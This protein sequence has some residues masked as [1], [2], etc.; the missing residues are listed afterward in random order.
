MYLHVIC[1]LVKGPTLPRG[2]GRYLSNPDLHTY[3]LGCC[4]LQLAL[5]IA[6]QRAMEVDAAI[7][8]GEPP[9]AVQEVQAA[10]QRVT[11]GA[12]VSQQQPSG[13][14]VKLQ[15]NVYGDIESSSDPRDETAWS[16]GRATELAFAGA[17]QAADIAE[18]GATPM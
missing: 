4:L 13:K 16:V 9:C 5:Q 15:G 14:Q 6:Y 18:T 3:N 11:L 17:S 8:E 7:R 12:P 10:T 1:D 2:H